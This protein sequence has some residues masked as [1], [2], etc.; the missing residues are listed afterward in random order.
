M[1]K[2]LRPFKYTTFNKH[3]EYFTQGNINSGVLLFASSL[4]ADIASVKSAQGQIKPLF[5]VTCNSILH[6]MRVSATQIHI[7]YISH[8]YIISVNVWCVCLC[9]LFLS[10]FLFWKKKILFIFIPR[11][12]A[13]DVKPMVDGNSENRKRRTG[14]KGSKTHTCSK[15]QHFFSLPRS[16]EEEQWHRAWPFTATQQVFPIIEL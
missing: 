1:K 9:F 8:I 4:W 3:K 6:I 2:N 5:K 16:S 10:F 13:Q 15:H 12:T 11:A 14:A 7:R